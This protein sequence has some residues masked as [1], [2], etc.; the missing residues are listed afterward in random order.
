MNNITLVGRLATDPRLERHQRQPDLHASDS[1]ST[2]AAA[3][4]ADFITI[5][6]LRHPRRTTTPSGSPRAD[7]SRVA[8]RLNHSPWTD[9]E[10]GNNRERYE[11]I[12]N[13]VS[14]LDSPTS[15]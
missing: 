7:S 11:V 12:A 13:H 15:E 2:E 8:G 4:G 6:M 10:T 3:D 1:P 9:N 5:V 14:Y